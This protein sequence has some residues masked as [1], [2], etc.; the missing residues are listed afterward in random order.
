[1]FIFV[2]QPRQAANAY[3]KP[4]ET[5]LMMMM[6]MN[7][8]QRQR[9]CHDRIKYLLLAL[10]IFISYHKIAPVSAT[11]NIHS[12]ARPTCT[13]T[14]RSSQHEER[15]ANDKRQLSRALLQLLFIRSRTNAPCTG[16]YFIVIVMWMSEQRSYSAGGCVVPSQPTKLNEYHC[17][18]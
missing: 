16:I 3:R 17:I 18:Q 9:C 14:H 5:M 4:R 2:R 7:R 1:M 8:M 13:H 6:M 11:H 15:C 12:R 10:I